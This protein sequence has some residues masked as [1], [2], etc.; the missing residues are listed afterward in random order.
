MKIWGKTFS[1]EKV[2]HFALKSNFSNLRKTLKKSMS[3][4]WAKRCFSVA[5]FT[6]PH[7]W[8]WANATKKR[9]KSNCPAQG[10]FAV[11]PS[12]MSRKT[13]RIQRVNFTCPPPPPPLWIWANATKKSPRLKDFPQ[14]LPV[15][16]AKH[17]P[18]NMP[19]EWRRFLILQIGTSF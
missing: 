19:K 11:C 1:P 8:I 13:S 10:E 5:F 16:D 3:T 12:M 6:Y 17:D 2:F 7:M 9:Q 14:F 15:P 4:H 18:G